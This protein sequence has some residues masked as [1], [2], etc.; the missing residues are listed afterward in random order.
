M[1]VGCECG[2][3]IIDKYLDKDLQAYYYFIQ[4]E[5]CEYYWEGPIY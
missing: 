5:E 4:C 1:V 2:K 3:C